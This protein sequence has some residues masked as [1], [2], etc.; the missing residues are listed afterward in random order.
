MGILTEVSRIP[1]TEETGSGDFDAGSRLLRRRDPAPRITG[2]SNTTWFAVFWPVRA[3]RA[4][5]PGQ[6]RLLLAKAG[7]P[8]FPGSVGGTPMDPGYPG[9]HGV[10]YLWS[11]LIASWP[12]GP[13]LMR[14]VGPNLMR[15]VGPYLCKARR[16]VSL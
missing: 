3:K 10:L 16:A 13:N 5:L 12:E 14:P 2:L 1:S 8:W 11:F 15:P 6:S 4:A 9:I 7:L